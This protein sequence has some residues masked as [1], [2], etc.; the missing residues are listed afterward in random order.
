METQHMLEADLR[1]QHR[2]ADGSW[3]ELTE[4]HEHANPADHDTERQWPTGRIFRC[5]SCPGAFSV[6]PVDAEP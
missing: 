5:K 1:L 4:D 2:H 3:V 6:T